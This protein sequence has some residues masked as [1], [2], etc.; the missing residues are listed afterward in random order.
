[1]GPIMNLIHESYNLIKNPVK[2]TQGY[3]QRD[4]NGKHCPWRE[5]YSFCAV[6]ALNFFNCKSKNEAYHGALCI[7]QRHSEK[8][9]GSCVQT[10]NDSS[11]PAISHQNVLRIFESIIERFPDRDPTEKEYTEGVWVSKLGE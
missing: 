7:L 10:V 6:G 11:P 5:G 4:I 2:W 9:F 8:M 1:M 3:Y